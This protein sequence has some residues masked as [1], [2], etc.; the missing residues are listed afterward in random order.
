MVR[1]FVY[2]GTNTKILLEIPVDAV[3]KSNRDPAFEI[4]VPVNY[5]LESGCSI[6]AAT[7]NAESFNVIAE[8]LDWTYFGSYRPEASKFEANGGMGT[9]STA[10]SNLDGTGTLVTII[11]A[12]D[13]GTLIQSINI[14][15]IVTTTPGMIRLFLYDGTNTKLFR[16]IPVPYCTK[17]A[18]AHSFSHQID[19]EGRD[20]ALK[21]N[22][23]L[24]ATTENAES[25]NV[26]IE[27]LN[28]SYPA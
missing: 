28:W 7:Q 12:E 9:V 24:K 20:F 19:F 18:I 21:A 15:A 22:W 2:D 25:F 14:K 10:N 17:S 23:S 3:T 27:G 5:Y 8:G 1:L 26:I 4:T 6:K 13:N 16:E 11:S